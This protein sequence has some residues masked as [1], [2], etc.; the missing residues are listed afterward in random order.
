M[1]ALD[2]PAGGRVDDT[3]IDDKVVR[4]AK[5]PGALSFKDGDIDITSLPWLNE[6]EAAYTGD[7]TVTKAE[8]SWSRVIFVSAGTV[9]ILAA[10][11]LMYFKRK[12][13]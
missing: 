1:F 8:Y 11:V 13:Q 5:E 3:R 7:R 9:L 2:V 10:L 6:H 4:I 12:R